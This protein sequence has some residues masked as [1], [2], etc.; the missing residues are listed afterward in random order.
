MKSKSINF[1]KLFVLLTLQCLP[2]FIIGQ[3]TF[4]KVY[5]T[6]YDKTARDIL[7]T[8]D[9]G[10]ILT[11][12]VNT[13]SLT[14]CNLYVMKTDNMG[15]LL[16]EKSFGGNKPEY[17][18]NILSTS[19]GNYFIIGYSFS[20]N[21]GDMDV[22][23]IKIDPSGNLLWQKTFGGSGNEEGHEIIQTGDGNYAIVGTTNSNTTSQDIFLMKIDLAGTQSWIKYYGGS[24]KEYGNSIKL[25]SDGGYI[26][27]GQTFS[28]GP[29]GLAYLIRTDSNGD[30]LWTKRYGASLDNEGVAIVAN[31]DGSFTYVERDSS[32]TSDVDIRVIKTDASGNKLWDK[33]YGSTLKD[34]PKSIC[35]T[36]DGGY[37]VGGMS[38]SFGWVN[39]DMWL[40][41]VN[42][43]GDTL[44]SRHFGGSDHEHCYKAKEWDNGY[45][46][47]GHSL[48]Y[49]PGQK[50]M[51]VKMNS[52][53][54]VGLNEY[55]ASNNE[56]NV[57]PNPSPDG[58]INIEVENNLPVK[59]RLI[60]ALGRVIYAGKTCIETSHV[61]DIGVQQQGIY[62]LTVE[63]QQGITT[64]KIVIGK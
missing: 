3:V 2:I 15:N 30:T 25:C 55:V 62:L 46:A 51:F 59:L 63:S 23:L 52:S 56:F 19:D 54:V 58:L 38:R 21:A 9:G 17:S 27:T 10:Y 37:L 31:S 8:S 43:G 28:S 47:A 18:Y 36:S 44:W 50:V 49:G 29:K 41:K 57:Y 33:L 34:T 39:P 1:S 40:L 42:A 24:G 16:W 45:I 64:R 6:T 22:Y 11:G 48:S 61:I 20:F 4:Q 32:S 26:I 12:Y 53:G 35:N 14:D 13:S 60:D 5:P 7:P